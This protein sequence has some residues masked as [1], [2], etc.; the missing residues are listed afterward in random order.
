MEKK[1]EKIHY[2]WFILGAC[3]LI[4]V[5]VQSLVMQVS[6]LY[7]LPMYNDLQIPRT[8]LSLQSVM[9]TVGAVVSAPVWGRMYKTKDARKLLPMSVAVTALC[10][11][12]RSFM[13]NIWCILPL[14][15]IKGIFFTG[16]TLLPISILLTAWFKEKRGFAISVATI[17]TSIGGVIFNPVV[18][19]LIS[20]Y[21]WRTADRVTGA[22]MF[23][24]TVPCL[25]AI[26]RNR[27][28]DKGLL[29]YGVTDIA[30]LK[31]NTQQKQE[32][33]TGMTMKEAMKSP[34]LYLFLFAVLAMTFANGAA[35]QTPTYLADIG[36]GTAV[37]ARAASAYAAVGILGKLILGSIVDKFGEKKG[38]IYICSIAT[39]AYICF[40]FAR[41]RVAFFGL[42]LFYGLSTGMVSVMPTLLTS[43]IFGNRDYGPI[44]GVVVSVNRFGGIVGNLLVSLLFD[45]TGNYSIIWPACAVMIVLTLISILTCMAMS[46][47]KMST[48]VPEAGAEA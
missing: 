5:I 3:V 23:V 20:S 12:G 18:E 43:K 32:V 13:P 7:I 19:K 8:L 33:L 27:P 26:I 15:F 35:L 41:S 10:T 6:A 2:A 31:G 36:Y 4:N 37:A 28:K 34:I 38:V 16:S 48:A 25:Y 39:I 40:I 1:R 17:G 46:K 42:I 47:K 45:I 29:P 22:L 30:A 21:G 9:I 44:Y 14:S 11:I 24:I